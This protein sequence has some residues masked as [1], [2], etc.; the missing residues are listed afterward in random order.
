MI[1]PG[2][3]L[4]MRMALGDQEL[5]RDFRKESIR[6]VAIRVKRDFT[7]EHLESLRDVS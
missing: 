5:I 2:A 3:F 4:L 7:D 1:I 6:I